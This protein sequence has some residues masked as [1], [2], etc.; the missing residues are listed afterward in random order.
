MA[1]IAAMHACDTAN[2]TKYINSLP[3]SPWLSNSK[4]ELLAFAC[5]F[6]RTAW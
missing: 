6:I 3:A 4:V 2:Q 5:A 1:M